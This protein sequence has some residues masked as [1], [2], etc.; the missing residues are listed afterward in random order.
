MEN[1]KSNVVETPP[2]PTTPAGEDSVDCLVRHYNS[3]AGAEG[4]ALRLAIESW[5]KKRIRKEM[6]LQLAAI[7]QSESPEE[8][9]DQLEYIAHNLRETGW[10]AGSGG[11]KGITMV[12][13]MFREPN[14]QDEGQPGKETSHV[15]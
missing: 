4:A 7:I 9:A 12:W 15:E 3:L 10:S 2:T 8:M 6:P 1:Q 5:E 11:G 13:E 14:V